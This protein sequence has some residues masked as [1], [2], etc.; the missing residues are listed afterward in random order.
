MKDFKELDLSKAVVLL[1]GGKASVFYVENNA[2][3]ARHESSSSP[4]LIVDDLFSKQVCLFVGEEL[5]SILTVGSGVNDTPCEFTL[6]PEDGALY[7]FGNGG[8]PDVKPN[9]YEV[10]TEGLIQSNVCSCK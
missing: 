1:K 5:V 4:C 3:F 6:K 10:T 8:V 7:V 2:L 9:I